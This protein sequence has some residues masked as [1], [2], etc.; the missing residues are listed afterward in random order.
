MVRAGCAQIIVAP[1]AQAVR[2]VA[3]PEDRP[4]VDFVEELPIFVGKRCAAIEYQDDQV[5]GFEMRPAARDAGT[6]DPVIGPP[7]PRGIRQ[8]DLVRPEGK[9]LFQPIP[10]GAWLVAY[11]CTLA[12]EKSV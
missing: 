12:A 7:D 8:E 2:L 6:F 11:Q 5:G 10:R 9:R 1:G 3:H 4:V